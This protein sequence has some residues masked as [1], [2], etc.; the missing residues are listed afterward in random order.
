MCP[1]RPRPKSAASCQMLLIRLERV[2]PSF[3]G[4]IVRAGRPA[5]SLCANIISPETASEVG[6]NGRQRRPT[7][8]ERDLIGQFRFERIVAAPVPRLTS[9]GIGFATTLDTS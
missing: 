1:G 9:A 7:R 5:R 3:A 2:P 4:D 8:A 6:L